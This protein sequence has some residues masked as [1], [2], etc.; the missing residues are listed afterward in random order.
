MGCILGP[1]LPRAM[2]YHA[3]EY[4]SQLLAIQSP[5][6]SGC[7]DRFKSLPGNGSPIMSFTG[8]STLV[9]ITCGAESQRCTS[10]SVLERFPA[11]FARLDHL[12]K[13]LNTR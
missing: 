4:A 3:S 6:W 8:L 7:S 13:A 2:G 12:V 11:P 1:L 5:S 10:S 9:Y